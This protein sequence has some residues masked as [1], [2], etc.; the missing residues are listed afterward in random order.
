ME[1]N[2]RCKTILTDRNYSRYTMSV[3]ACHRLLP[4]V[5][6]HR[7][8]VT[9]GVWRQCL[10]VVVSSRCVLDPKDR[11]YCQ[12]PGV[13]NSWR[14]PMEDSA[15]RRQT[16]Y[17][18]QVGDNVC[19]HPV[20]FGDIATGAFITDVLTYFTFVLTYV[21]TIYLFKYFKYAK[22]AVCRAQP[23]FSTSVVEQM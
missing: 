3:A 18:F 20:A 19:R 21:V 13:V 7:Y 8:P 17:S 16:V 22:G 23:F 1:Y 15:R 9:V 6:I 10:A 11:M 14:G 12:A 4:S 5:S 2:I